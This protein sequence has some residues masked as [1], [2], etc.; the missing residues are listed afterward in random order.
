[1][2]AVALAVTVASAQENRDLTDRAYGAGMAEADKIFEA[3][4]FDALARAN[5]LRTRYAAIEA[6]IELDSIVGGSFA[7]L[8]DAEMQS[9]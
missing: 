1:M 6:R 3:L 5:Q 8:V 7:A 2:H 9:K 4:M